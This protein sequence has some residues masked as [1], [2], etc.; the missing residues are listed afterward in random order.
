MFGEASEISRNMGEYGL[1]AIRF[2]RDRLVF[3]GHPS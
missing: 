2:T 1:F 3:T